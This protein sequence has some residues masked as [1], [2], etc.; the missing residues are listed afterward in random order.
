MFQ[1]SGAAAQSSSSRSRQKLPGVM[2]KVLD[3]LP[4]LRLLVAAGGP[5]AAAGGLVAE[6]RRPKLLLLRLRA[7]AFVIN[8]LAGTRGHRYLVD[9]Q[10]KCLNRGTW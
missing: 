6:L 10:L 8:M 2:L 5:G 9:R 1:V 3:L 7:G 4:E